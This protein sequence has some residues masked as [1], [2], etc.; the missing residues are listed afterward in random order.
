M[1]KS[2]ERRALAFGHG[3][4]QAHAQDKPVRACA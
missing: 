3:R 1:K 4:M 2:F